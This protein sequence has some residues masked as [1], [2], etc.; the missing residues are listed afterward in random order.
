MEY[1]INGS[2]LDYIRQVKYLKETVAQKYFRQLISVLEYCHSRGV[3]HRDV[4]CENLL[5]DKNFNL[6]L[7]D[8]GFARGDLYP[9]TSSVSTLNV[10]SFAISTSSSSSATSKMLSNTFCGSY[11]YACPEILKGIPYE[12]QL[13][14]I[15]ASGVVLYAMLFGRLPFDDTNYKQLI[16]V[17]TKFH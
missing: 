9:T 17:F 14:D 2:L 10:A 8:F 7:I 12:P 15:W 3:V 16:K 4:K 11:A 6:K 13:A 5:L 1:A